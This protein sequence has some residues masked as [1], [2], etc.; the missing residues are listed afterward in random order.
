MSLS[1]ISIIRVDLDVGRAWRMLGADLGMLGDIDRGS[2]DGT[3]D[4]AGYI[5]EAVGS[6]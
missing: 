2:V 6:A 5:D 4:R 1:Q 3:A